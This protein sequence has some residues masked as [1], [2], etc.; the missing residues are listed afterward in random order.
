[1]AQ[2][3]A[4]FNWATLVGEVGTPEVAGF[5]NA[6]DQVN[7]LAER[8]DGFVWRAGNEMELA[9]QIDWPLFRD[10]RVIASFSVWETP[11]AFET[12]VYKTVHGVFY[13]RRNEWFILD[14]PRGY[15]LW[16][17]PAGH[18]PE[19]AEAKSHVD[20]FVKEGANDLAFDLPFARSK[21]WL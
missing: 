13:R 5:V 19:I 8:L 12:F 2:H 14:A 15:V 1:V 3:L 17:V 9:Q 10:P 20:R 11:A 6:V 18:Q 4:H 21:G 16:W 7:S